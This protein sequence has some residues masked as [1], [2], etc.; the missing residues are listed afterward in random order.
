MT[1]RSRGSDLPTST[2]LKSGGQ[3]HGVRM[4]SIWEK[5][6]WSKIPS[7]WRRESGLLTTSGR[8]VSWGEKSKNCKRSVI[9]ET[10]LAFC[11]G[12][13]VIDA[14]D[15]ECSTLTFHWGQIKP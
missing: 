1:R 15:G 8:S 12:G 5:E 3:Q 11:S 4:T 9:K 7:C 14:I 6:V 13:F 2:L 10:F